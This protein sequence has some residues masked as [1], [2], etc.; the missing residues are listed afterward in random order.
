MVGRAEAVVAVAC[1]EYT[2]A[3][4]QARPL[5]LVDSWSFSL[6]LFGRFHPK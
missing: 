1:G 6:R 2:V 3:E 5:L 4:T